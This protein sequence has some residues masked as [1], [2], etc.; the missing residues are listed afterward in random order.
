[1]AAR[2]A[3]PGQNRVRRILL[4]AVPEQS[5]GQGG[6]QFC[7]TAPWHP[8]LPPSFIFPWA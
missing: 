6:P 2:Q 5:R 3:E 4:N 7:S 1:M 8:P